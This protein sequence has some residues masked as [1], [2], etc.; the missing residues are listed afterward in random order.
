MAD[1]IFKAVWFLSLMAVL[2]TLLY[3]YASL[4]E[5]IQLR[6]GGTMQWISRNGLFYLALAI[7]GLSNALVFAVGRLVPAGEPY[8]RPWFYMLIVFFN[9]FIIV[10]LQFFSLYNSAEKFNYDNI[11]FI[12]YG[13]VSLLVVWVTLW[14]L[15]MIIQRMLPKQGITDGAND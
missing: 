6:E 1:K 14:P 4:P 5:S 11:G 13:S 8:F 2:V 12:I 9:V 10:S 7:L 15:R 3:T